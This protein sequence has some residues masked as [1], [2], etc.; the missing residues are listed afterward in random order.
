MKSLASHTSVTMKSNGPTFQPELRA[1]SD[2]GDDGI[3]VIDVDDDDDDSSDLPA[4]SA[5]PRSVV[6][7]NN[8]DGGELEPEDLA[9]EVASSASSTTMEL[10]AKFEPTS[11]PKAPKHRRKPEKGRVSKV[12]V[13]DGS[14]PMITD[15]SSLT[16]EPAPGASTDAGSA[17]NPGPRKDSENVDTAELDEQVFRDVLPVAMSFEA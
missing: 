9:F 3:D 4:R 17:E 8:N 10:P 6:E 11:S 12:V 13:T 1:I 5:T 14:E 2:A 7:D 15:A 16:P